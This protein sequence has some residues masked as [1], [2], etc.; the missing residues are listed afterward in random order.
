MKP[1]I[2]LEGCDGAGKTTLRK[3]L[4]KA[5]VSI[6]LDTITIG[7]HSWL[8]PWNARALVAARDQRC[9]VSREHLSA[10][11]LQD[12]Q[13][14]GLRNVRPALQFAAVI[15]DRW[16]YSDAV[17]H[18]VLYDIPS[19]N[20]LELHKQ[21]GTLVPDLLLYVAT[22]PDRAYSR[23][24]ERGRQTRHYERPSDLHR[25]TAEYERLLSMPIGDRPRVI[26]IPN[27]AGIDDLHQQVESIIVPHVC[28]IAGHYQHGC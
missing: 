22:D 17:Y 11:Y 25:I 6:G 26:R 12:K 9:H 14:H 23:I 24:L 20:T 8:N 27:V 28:D 15:A 5:L 16:F 13:L 10:A 2:A 7:Q 19:E 3:M 1:F 21:A 4:C 18:S